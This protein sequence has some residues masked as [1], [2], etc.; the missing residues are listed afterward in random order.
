[1]AQWRVTY[2]HDG[3]YMS[4]TVVVE[5]NSKEESGERAKRRAT[6]FGFKDIKIEQID[7]L[8]DSPLKDHIALIVEG[9][10]DAKLGPLVTAL[11]RI[12]VTVAEVHNTSLV[13]HG[14]VWIIDQD[15][16]PMEDV[17]ECIHQYNGGA[18]VR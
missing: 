18:P 6:A 12:G 16:A 3:L 13:D 2:S 7:P 10:S 11:S 17:V 15:G 14:Y 9:L 1:M 8:S 4:T 5:A